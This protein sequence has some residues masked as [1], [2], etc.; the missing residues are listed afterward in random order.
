MEGAQK[1]LKSAEVRNQPRRV[2]NKPST[3]EKKNNSYASVSNYKQPR[4]N[5]QRPEQSKQ[6]R[7]KCERC[8][9]TSHDASKCRSKRTAD[10]KPLGDNQKNNP[11]RTQNRDHVNVVE[12]NNK[13]EPVTV[14]KIAAVRAKIS[15]S[16]AEGMAANDDDL[17]PVSFNGKMV[18][19]LLDSGA[20]ISLIDNKI[21]KRYKWP[22]SPYKGPDLV[23]A[24][25][26]N[27]DLIGEVEVRLA[28]T[29]GQFEKSV[30]TK[31][32][33]VKNLCVDAILG[34]QLMK[35]LEMVLNLVTGKPSF[36][37][38]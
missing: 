19:T 26:S 29:I 14:R 38:L 5:S 35:Q 13:Q 17:Y 1:A 8:G 6:P 33:V 7:K 20:S 15:A 36:C 32:I 23:G 4:E 34:T 28:I 31:I 24:N 25:K 21:V 11:P 18:K 9:F 3:Y 10:G 16:V 30:K 37:G 27:L 12:K 2:N 22:I